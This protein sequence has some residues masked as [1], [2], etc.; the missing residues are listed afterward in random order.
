MIDEYTKGYRAGREL[1]R[2]EYKTLLE[3]LISQ[4]KNRERLPVQEDL[5]NVIKE[6]QER[7]L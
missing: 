7:P 3:K 4:Y 2:N 1:G 6:V 5:E